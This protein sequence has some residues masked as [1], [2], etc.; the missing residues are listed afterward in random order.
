MPRLLTNPS[1]PVLGIS[2]SLG[3]ATE[4]AFAITV[5]ALRISVGRLGKAG[6][7]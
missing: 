7:N 1:T 6:M 3:Q 4:N 5:Q 2:A